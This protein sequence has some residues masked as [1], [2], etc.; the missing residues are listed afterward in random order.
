VRPDLLL[1]V[2]LIEVWSGR[3]RP[4]Q[5]FRDMQ[6]NYVLQWAGMGICPSR[7]TWY[8]FRDR[9]GPFLDQWLRQTLQIAREHGLTP[10]R[11]GSLDGSLLAANASRHH[12]LNEERLSKRQAALATRCAR[13][14]QGEAAEATPAWMAKTPATRVAQA[15]RYERAQARLQEFQAINQRQNPARRRHLPSHVATGTGGDATAVGSHGDRRKLRDGVQP[16]DLRGREGDAVR[17]LA[18]ERLHRAAKRPRPANDS[19]S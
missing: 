3:Q 15:H 17:S 11:R 14:G 5:W 6:E 4:S 7:S 16:R 9:Q 13:D 2:V 19:Q 8:N 10:A 12:L 1:G 18:G